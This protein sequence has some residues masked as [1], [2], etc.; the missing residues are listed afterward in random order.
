MNRISILF[1]I[2]GIFLLAACN[3]NTNKI[4][5][6]IDSGYDYF[7]L[8]I[9]KYRSYKVDSLIF[10]TT[11]QGVIVDTTSSFIRETYIDTL[12]DNEGRL[13]YLLWDVYD[14]MLYAPKGKWS[15]D[16]PFALKLSYLRSLLC[17]LY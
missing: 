5:L 2:L 12:S 4:E 16:K 17:L 15:H 11:A 8:Q 14:A 10:D 13:T 1:S 7:P 3:E 9:G 6:E